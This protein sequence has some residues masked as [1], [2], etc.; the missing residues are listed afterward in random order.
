MAQAF[1]FKHFVAFAAV[2]PG[3]GGGS[4]NP[5]LLGSSFNVGS[6]LSLFYRIAMPIA[7]ILALINI[8]KAAYGIMFSEGDPR[9]V[10]ESKEDLTSAIMGLLFV[11]LSIALLRIIMGQIIIGGSAGF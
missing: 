4:Y 2:D 11:L 3:E 5:A 6:F 7:V 1:L 10:S 9:R 8:A